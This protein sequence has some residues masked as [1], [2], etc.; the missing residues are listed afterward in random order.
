[1]LDHRRLD[2]VDLVK[3]DIEGA[4]VDAL[5]GMT[6]GLMRRRY[7]YALV[8][9]HPAELQARGASIDDCVGPFARAGYRAW[10][11]DHSPDMHRRAAAGPVPV[12]ELLS[13]LAPGSAASEHW[14]HFLFVAPGEAAPE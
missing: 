12:A 7:R 6:A 11:I 8:E 3:I 5:R 9:C 13:P 2:R 1:L 10:R 14:P 4:E